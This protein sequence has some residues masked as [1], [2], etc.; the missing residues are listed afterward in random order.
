MRVAGG[1]AQLLDEERPLAL[2]DLLKGY[3]V[4]R[5]VSDELD[6][7]PAGPSADHVLA[8]DLRALELERERCRFPSP[9][10]FPRQ[11][12]GPSLSLAAP[13]GP[14]M[15][16]PVSYEHL[17]PRVPRH[18]TPRVNDGDEGHVLT[19]C[20]NGFYDLVAHSRPF[21]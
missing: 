17:G 3:P 20:R 9:D 21:P 1:T 7:D 6:E 10:A 4:G 8:L 16:R 13:H 18:R 19:T 15:D 12:D 14:Q 2:A 11:R 5:A